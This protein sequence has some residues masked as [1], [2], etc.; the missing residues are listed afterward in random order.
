M[1]FAVLSMPIQSTLGGYTRYPTVVNLTKRTNVSKRL[2][3]ALRALL[4]LQRRA[5]RT[6]PF[7]PPVPNFVTVK[8]FPTP[9]DPAFPIAD[10]SSQPPPRHLNLTAPA[11]PLLIS[12][13]TF[14]KELKELRAQLSSD[15]TQDLPSTEPPRLARTNSGR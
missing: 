8:P 3:A 9:H 10:R 6:Q 11:A 1:A 5:V 14:A 13:P 12:A 7:P 15:T 4:H 2:E